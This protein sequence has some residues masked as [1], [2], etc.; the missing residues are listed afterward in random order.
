MTGLTWVCVPGTQ[1]KGGSSEM[2][3]EAVKLPE[4]EAWKVSRNV[5]LGKWGRF[6]NSNKGVET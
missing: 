1:V 6:W 2:R 5:S 3:E 4:E